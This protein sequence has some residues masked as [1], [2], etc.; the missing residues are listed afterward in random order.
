V[1]DS[2]V[3]PTIRERLPD[4][5][6]SRVDVEGASPEPVGRGRGNRSA[7]SLLLTILGLFVVPMTE[8]VW[9]ST[10]TR[11]LASVSIDSD[12][13]RQALAR[14]SKDGW[15]RSSRV[16]RRARWSLTDE[17]R[18]LLADGVAHMLAF[19]DRADDWPGTG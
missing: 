6:R 10:L 4:L 14:A 13:A 3:K 16:G 15:I 5:R 9:A 18:S 2:S 19:A 8:P 12:N 7:R 1:A 11:A 17:G